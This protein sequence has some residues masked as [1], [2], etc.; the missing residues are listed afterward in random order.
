VEK[1]MITSIN[2]SIISLLLCAAST[3][4]VAGGS[5]EASTEALNHSLQAV[6]YSLQA[7]VKLASGALAI[8]FI[9][10]G[11]IGK[12]SGEVGHG[13]WEEANSPPTEPLPV[14]DE[15]ITIGPNPADQLEKQE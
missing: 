15:I 6:G 9:T 8:P 7:G 4:A 2:K 13:L 1:N 11:E 10:V 14:S 5:V 3:T 12:V